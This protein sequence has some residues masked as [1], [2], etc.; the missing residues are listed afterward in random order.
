MAIP[1]FVAING[2]HIPNIVRLD[3]RSVGVITTTPGASGSERA[4]SNVDHD[5]LA[6]P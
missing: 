5:P 1:N 6:I 3:A 4:R 2:M